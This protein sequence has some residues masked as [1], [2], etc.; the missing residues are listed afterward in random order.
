MN[1]SE[2]INPGAPVTASDPEETRPELLL[3]FLG[4]CN[5]ATAPSR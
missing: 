2:W 5:D 4:V 1:S 3:S